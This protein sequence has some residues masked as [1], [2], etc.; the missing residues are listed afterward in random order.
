MKCAVILA[1]CGRADGSEVQESVSVLIHCARVGLTARCFAPDQPQADVINHATGKPAQ[2]S[3]NLLVE[4]ARISRGEISPITQLHARDFDALIFPG[5]FGAAKNLCNFASKGALCDVHPEVV[6]VIGEFKAQAKPTGFICIA[7]VIAARTLGTS[8][9]C[10]LTIGSDPDTARAIEAM[11][12]THVNTPTTACHVDKKHRVVS[13]PAYMGDA[14]PFE[15]FTGIGK[16]V[17]EVARMAKEPG[18]Q[19]RV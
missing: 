19:R 16:L 13:T 9:G 7:P 12:G 17:E 10:E 2:E 1:G 11:G 8:G 6:R 5:G 14:T 15:I 3:R 18:A 4:A